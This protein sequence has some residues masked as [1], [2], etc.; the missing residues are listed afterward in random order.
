MRTASSNISDL[1]RGRSVLITG[2]LG[3]IGSNLARRLATLN[4][5]KIVILDALIPGQGGNHFNLR[6]L[7]D[8]ITI[9]LSDMRDNDVV[10]NYVVKD[11]A[12]FVKAR[13]TR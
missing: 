8:R 5:V 10:L 6:G 2:G 11:L 12:T 1:Y 13:K 7:E 4:D 9:H 3:F